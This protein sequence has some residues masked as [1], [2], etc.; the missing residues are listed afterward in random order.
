M[1]IP[2]FLQYIRK[3]YSDAC[4]KNWKNISYD[5]LYIDINH[6]LHH[7]CY[8]SKNSEDLLKKFMEYLRKII[9]FIKPKKRIYLAA[10]GPAPIAK[11]ILQRKRRLDSI[12]SSVP[13]LRSNEG[14]D[15]NANLNLNFTPG[16][17]F[18]T[19][20]EKE[21]KGFIVYLKEKLK[22]EVITS[23][24]D[25]DESEIKIR[26]QVQK[27]Q[28]RYSNETHLV[29]SGDSD[30]IL[31]LFTCC[32]L[33][34]IYQ[35]IDKNTIIHFGTLLE[36]HMK[37]FGK[38][39]SVKYDFV[40]INLM[41][42]NDYIPKVAYLKL[43]NIWDAYK[44]ISKIRLTGLIC[45]QDNKIKIDPIFI[46]D[47]LYVATKKTQTH[48][49]KKFKVTELKNL[50]YV[51]YV[52]GL[53]WCFGMYVTG[54]CSDYK[55]I[56][57][58]HV[59][60]HVTGVMLTMMFNSSHIITKTDSIDADLYSILLIPEKA[61]ALLSHEQKLIA[62]KL[63][64]KQP[65]IYEEERCLKCKNYCKLLTKLNKK[66]KHYEHSSDECV[67]I[68]KRISKLNV[69]FSNHIATHNKLSADTIESII[70]DFM[71]IREELRET[72]SLDSCTD[73][74]TDNTHYK[75]YKPIYIQRAKILKKRIF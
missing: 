31:L 63:I 12:K 62:E 28:N 60:P 61:N 13:Y 22:I 48:L 45:Y 35:M 7:V 4:K 52:K 2:K 75:P 10:D 8:L 65:I 43:E 69:N 17:I 49:L 34:K 21:L 39:D 26:F 19:N 29:Y 55:Y 9:M 20:L 15:L 47:L 70:K 54:D 11:M 46:H 27:F 44:I 42:G 33:S 23:I 74:N 32:D 30:M 56:Y 25:A 6:V 37:T 1:G 51:N 68:K 67:D 16:T 41:M 40:F 38:T 57:E 72:I 59:S 3:T 50:S 53:Y 58:H 14:I 71:I 36:H 18:M 24:V 5:N 73:D 66:I 64:I